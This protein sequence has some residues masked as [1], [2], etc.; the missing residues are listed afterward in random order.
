MIFGPDFPEEIRRQIE[1]QVDQ[2][3]MVNDAVR[4]AIRALI[5][6]LEVD[7]LLALRYILTMAQNRPESAHFIE[8]MVVQTMEIKYDV[9]GGCGENHAE[10]DLLNHTDPPGDTSPPM[11]RDLVDLMNVYEVDTGPHPGSVC[12]RGCGRSFGSMD[13]R[14]IF[15]PGTDGC[16]G[17]QKLRGER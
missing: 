3:N 17:C 8:G 14:M 10:R 9:C 12:C 5:A 6:G 16:P 11:N 13:D 2:Q 1:E 7:E 15:N 4:N